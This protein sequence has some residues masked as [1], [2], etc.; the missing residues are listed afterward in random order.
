MRNTGVKTITNNDRDANSNSSGGILI[1]PA[2]P[3]F[4]PNITIVQK[5]DIFSCFLLGC[6]ML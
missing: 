5:I 3:S 4:Y 1:P 6:K 2:S